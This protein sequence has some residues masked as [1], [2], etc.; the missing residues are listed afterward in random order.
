M[1]PHYTDLTGGVPFISGAAIQQGTIAIDDVE[2][3]LLASHHGVM[4]SS[5]LQPGMLVAVRKGELGNSAVVGSTIKEINCSSEVMYFELHDINEAGFLQSFFN[6]R[7]GRDA[8]ERQQRGMM[9]PGISLLDVPDIVVPRLRPE[10]G[11]YIGSKVHQAEGLREKAIGIQSSIRDTLAPLAPTGPHPVSWRV[12]TAG[13]ETHRLNAK[14]YDPVVRD[15]LDVARLRH[16]LTPLGDIIGRTGISSGA[17]PAGASYPAQGVMFARVQNVKPYA[18]DRSDVVF[19]GAADD[20]VLRQSRCSVDDLVLTITGNPGTA[21]LIAAEDL[22]LNLNQHSVRFDIAH[23]WLPGFIAA[24]LNSSFGKAQVDRLAV[25][26][27]RAALDHSSVRELL[28]PELP[29]ATMIGIDERVRTF[30]A[31]KRGAASLVTAARMLVDALIERKV[32]E[33]EL[34]AAAAEP[35]ADRALLTRI[36]NAGLDA[37]GEPL[38]RD[39]DALDALLKP[40]DP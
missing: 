32:T 4:A 20:I 35:A 33:A 26:G 1:T 31:C 29:Q 10:S 13:L 2:H 30:G 38:F 39:L 6:S 8:F 25:G 14:H 17:T 16:R 34:I 37:P 18:I 40:G 23:P 24:T 36:T 28:V 9:I 3:V 27:T 19:I 21:A 15:M 7:F 11:R 12:G 22:P 5:R